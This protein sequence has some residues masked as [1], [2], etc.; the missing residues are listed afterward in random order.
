MSCEF[1]LLAGKRFGVRTQEAQT[2]GR[3]RVMMLL[4]GRPAATGAAAAAAA[5]DSGS[6]PN[7]S[8]P[9]QSFAWSPQHPLAGHPMSPPPQPQ[10]GGYP[11]HAPDA[12]HP[13]QNQHQQAGAGWW[14]NVSAQ[15]HD[16]AANNDNTAPGPSAIGSAV[17]S[18]GGGPR[19][20]DEFSVVMHSHWAHLAIHV[21]GIVALCLGLAG[22]LHPM[23]A[24]VPPLFPDPAA[25]VILGVGG[26]IELAAGLIFPPYLIMFERK[27]GMPSMTVWKLTVGLPPFCFGFVHHAPTDNV[28]TM[29]FAINSWITFSTNKLGQ[30]STH[31]HSALVIAGVG[32][33]SMNVEEVAELSAVLHRPPTTGFGEPDSN[34]CVF[35]L[36]SCGCY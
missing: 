22:T 11:L 13:Q 33:H 6:N 34:L 32:V 29:E 23:V 19:A 16:V 10:V 1:V 2:A 9:P 31:H 4:I 7:V 24:R 30:R 18:G 20:D 12:Q 17:H 14:Y 21:V 8:A 26:F 25:W 3:D 28:D 27:R 36:C 15:D 35:C 5:A